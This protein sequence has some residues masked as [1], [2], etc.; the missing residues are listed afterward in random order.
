MLHD[1][2]H[3]L[4]FPSKPVSRCQRSGN[5]AE[6]DHR[7]AVRYEIIR[8]SYPIPPN[9][10]SVGMLR[11]RPPVISL[12]IKIMRPSRTAFRDAGGYRYRF[13]VQGIIR[14]SEE[15]TSELQSLMRIS[16]AVFC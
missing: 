9:I 11:I 14:R 15:H 12:R 7:Q 6:T 5:P 16:Y 8:V 2:L 13:L 3:I 4:V 10:R 1:V